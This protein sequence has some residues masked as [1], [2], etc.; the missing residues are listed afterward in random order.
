MANV[1]LFKI[2]KKVIEKNAGKPDDEIKF[3]Y[4]PAT[5]RHM[6][7]T[8]KALHRIRDGQNKNK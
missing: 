4:G 8:I 6:I 3:I 7:K 5:Y 1:D 2:I